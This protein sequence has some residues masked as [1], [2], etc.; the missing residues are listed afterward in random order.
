MLSRITWPALLHSSLMIQGFEQCFVIG[1]LLTIVP[2]LTRTHPCHPLELGGAL[3]SVIGFGA[4]ALAGQVPLAQGFFLLGMIVLL[5]AT[6][7]RL[8]RRQV[9]PPEEFFFVAIGLAFG[10]VGGLILL[11]SSMGV[12]AEP[13]PG[14]GLRLISL[15]MVLTLV[16]GIGGILV[17][18]FLGIREN[19]IMPRFDDRA[20]RFGRRGLYIILG[21]VLIL[22]F[23]AEAAGHETFGFWLRTVVVTVMLLFVWRIYRMPRKRDLPAYVLWASSWG[24]LL[25]LWVATLFP[26]LETAG[27]HLTLIAGFGVMTMTIATRISVVHGGGAVPDEQQVLTPQVVA[28]LILAIIT[29]FVAHISPVGYVTWLAAS[30]I[31]WAI[32]WLFWTVGVLPRIWRRPSGTAT[33][34]P[35]GTPQP[36]R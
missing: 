33:G 12:G 23:V 22:G 31:F 18:G 1:F 21:C 19:V 7:H 15:G 16:I 14:F 27:L 3:L 9:D 25:G 13:A 29:N 36:P 11:L 26:L 20:E 17:P 8:M 34:G 6:G 10:F 2:R 28:P 4:A 24:V 5:V 32:G 35:Q 30:G